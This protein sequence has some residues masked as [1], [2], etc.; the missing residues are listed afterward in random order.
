MNKK[1]ILLKR[2][3]FI[4]QRIEQLKEELNQIEFELGRVV[5]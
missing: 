5:G 2:H 4:S 1:E 3:Y